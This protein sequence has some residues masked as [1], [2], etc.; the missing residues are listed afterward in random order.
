MSDYHPCYLIHPYYQGHPQHLHLRG[1]VK[2]LVPHHSL[3]ITVY[4][5]DTL[6][7]T[8]APN[9]WLAS[10]LGLNHMDEVLDDT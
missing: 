1:Q 5:W 7:G 6:H 2:H 3:K 4:L 9:K 10:C 8:G